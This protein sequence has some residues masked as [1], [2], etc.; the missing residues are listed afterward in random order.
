MSRGF[1]GSI[2]SAVL[3]GLTTAT[4]APA[5]TDFPAADEEPTLVEAADTPEPLTVA[6]TILYA[7]QR[8]AAALREVDA[9]LLSDSWHGEARQHW[10]QAV[11]RLAAENRY[12]LS[13]SEIEITTVYFS[14][15]RT[16]IAKTIEFWDYEERDRTSDEVRSSGALGPLHETYY[17]ESVN[18]AWSILRFVISEEP[19]LTL[20]DIQGQVFLNG[21]QVQDDREVFEGDEI[22]TAL[23]SSAILLYPFDGITEMRQDG[24]IRL[25]LL[26]VDPDRAASVRGSAEVELFSASL[27]DLWNRLTKTVRVIFSALGRRAADDPAEFGVTLRDDGTFIVAVEEGEVEL[28]SAGVTIT[29]RSG[30]QS[31]ALPGLP[32]VP[33]LPWPG[34]PLVPGIDLV[35]ST[36]ELTGAPRISTDGTVEVPLRVI[37]R[38]QGDTVAGIFKLHVE[39]TSPSG[40]FVAPFSVP[41]EASA[42]YPFAR[43]VLAPGAD[44]SFEGVVRLP[45]ELA[46]ETISLTAVADSCAG[47]EFVPAFCRVEESEEGNNEATLQQELPE[48]EAA[49]GGIAGTVW[50]DE[51]FDGVGES[52][53]ADAPVLLGQGA[54]P[55]TGFRSTATDAKGAFSFGDLPPGAYCVTIDIEQQCDVASAPTTPKE[56]T[57]FVASGRQANAGVFAF[58]IPIC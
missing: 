15:G 46:G 6:E 8:Y 30:E 18:G 7:N 34:P 25:N 54:C 36:I 29:L 53:Y 39:Y 5:P 41:G 27:T 56:R 12:R 17:L 58:A 21:E 43:G 33:P 38:N 11:Q 10:E 51:N 35:I 19:S 9:G 16:A 42:F 47:E 52:P 13:E 23:E 26:R 28:T 14:P 48:A 4:C 31:Y 45:G 2:G 37:A 57:L 40:N 3:L 24:H 20:T 1:L 22:A 32:P 49:L 44:T 50:V 55:A